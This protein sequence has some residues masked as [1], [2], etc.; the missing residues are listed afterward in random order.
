MPDIILQ[1]RP[2][3]DSRCLKE[4]V[5]GLAYEIIAHVNDDAS[6]HC[7]LPH[8]NSD[9]STSYCLIQQKSP[10]GN[11]TVNVTSSLNFASN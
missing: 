6:H 10:L 1:A 9:V 8:D 3:T 2:F 7:A 5:K 11:R 4:S